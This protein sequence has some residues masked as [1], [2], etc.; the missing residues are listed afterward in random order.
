VSVTGEYKWATA[1]FNTI[2]EDYA[3]TG[4]QRAARDLWARSGLGPGD[5]DVAL[6]YDAFTPPC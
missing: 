6:F 4:L 3:S 5:V 1:S 2:G